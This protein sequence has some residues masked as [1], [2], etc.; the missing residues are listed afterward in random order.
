MVMPELVEPAPEGAPDPEAPDAEVLDP[1]VAEVPDAPEAEVPDPPEAE[2][3]DAPEVEEPD[4]PDG[5]P[6]PEAEVLDPPD[7]E[8]PD[9]PDADDPDPPDAAFVVM[10]LDPDPEAPLVSTELEAVDPVKVESKVWTDERAFLTVVM[11]TSM[12]VTWLLRE[13][14][15]SEEQVTLEDTPVISA[16]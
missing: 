5:A 6:D 12:R 2:V 16:A 1:P 3:P 15:S 7:A 13:F 4:A 10:L 11:A 8:V 14:F 9:P